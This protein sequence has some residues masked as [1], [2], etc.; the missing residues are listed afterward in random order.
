MVKGLKES[1]KVACRSILCMIIIT[2]LYIRM[3]H[4]RTVN[5]DTRRALLICPEI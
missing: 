5:R 3:I 4:I 2:V 1:G